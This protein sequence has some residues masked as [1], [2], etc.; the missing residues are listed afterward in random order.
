[1]EGYLMACDYILQVLRTSLKY[2][3]SEELE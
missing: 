2:S 3:E 1:V